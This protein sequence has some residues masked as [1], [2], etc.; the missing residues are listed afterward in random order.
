MTVFELSYALLWVLALV[1]VVATVLLLYLLAQLQE[2]FGRESS[3]FG[4]NLIGRKLPAFQ[5]I[6]ASTGV[7]RRL[8]EFGGH[9]HVIL[10]LT[11]HCSACKSLA[12]ELKNTSEGK[13]ASLRLLMLC[14][15]GDADCR[16]V[17]REIR[18]VPVLLWDA[19]DDATSELWYVGFPAAL[20]VDGDGLVVDVRHPLSIGGLASAVANSRRERVAYVPN[21]SIATTLSSG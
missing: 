7:V 18:S 1:L 15:G 4:N 17:S 16:S 6:D 12:A 5:P 14:M 11:P 21:R 3:G 10:M 19:N 8:D 20:I 2:Q 9:E 13:L